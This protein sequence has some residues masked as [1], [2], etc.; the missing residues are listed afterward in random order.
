MAID[1]HDISQTSGKMKN[2]IAWT[3]VTWLFSLALLGMG[4]EIRI[5]W[6]VLKELE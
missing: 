5:I 2:W 6:S 1:L 3:L 4:E